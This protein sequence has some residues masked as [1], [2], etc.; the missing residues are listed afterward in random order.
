[1]NHLLGVFLMVPRLWISKNNISSYVLVSAAYGSTDSKF[2]YSRMKGQLEED[3]KALNFKKLI[4]L[5][6][7][8]LLRKDTDRTAEVLFV[9]TIS[10]FN[11]IG[12]L[13]SN[14]PLPTSVLAK[15]MI[16]CFGSLKDGEYCFEA[17]SI[18]EK[19]R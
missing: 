7:S 18:W 12:L 5:K 13:K 19:G 14:K 1:M 15:A 17:K 9:K 16:S 8:V 10:L 11:K 4:I 6:P 3:V 2:F